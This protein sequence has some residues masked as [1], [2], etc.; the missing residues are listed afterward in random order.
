MDS[1]LAIAGGTQAHAGV[2]PGG[3]FDGDFGGAFAAPRPAAGP[4]R[5]VNNT[6]A[7]AAVRAGL[8]DAEN[9]ARTD[10]LAVAPAR[11][12]GLG[13]RA[14]FRPAAAAHA[15]TGQLVEG[16][17]L[18]ATL[19]RFQKG[20]FHVVAQIVPAPAVLG[21]AG[22]PA[23]EQVVKNAA[24]A[25]NFAEDFARI[26]ESAGAG[27]ARGARA[28]GGVAVAV[29]GGARI[30]IVEDLVGLAQFLEIIFRAFVVGI[31]VGMILQASLR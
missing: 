18:L 10:H 30:G 2:H 15:R 12:A 9:A 20:N 11:R 28:E 7:P 13:G 31:A 5:F 25:E 21:G 24:A 26:V 14:F 27:R 29:V 4:A 8:G 22:P 19:R 3:N 16:D 1:R 6:P 17:F 23:A